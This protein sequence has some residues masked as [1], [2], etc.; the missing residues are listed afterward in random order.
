MQNR[1]VSLKI[2]FSLVTLTLLQNVKADE[3]MWLLFNLSAQKYQKM[4]SLGLDIAKD[5]LFNHTAPSLKDAIVSLNNGSCTGSFISS[6]GLIITNHHC[7]L[8]DVQ[9]HSSV[10]NN[11][12]ENGFWAIN[13]SSELPNPGQTASVLIEALDVTDHILKQIPEKV[14]EQRR[15]FLIDSISNEIITKYETNSHYKAEISHF[16]EGNQFILLLSEVFEDVRLVAS[17]PSSIGQ[18]GKEEDNWMWP[19]HAADFAL[20]RVYTGPDGKPAPYNEKNIPYNPKRVL[21]INIDGINLNDFTMV[22]GFPGSTQRFISSYGIEEIEQVINPVIKDVRGTKQ[23]IWEGSM[24]SNPDIK[25]QYASKFA[26]SSNYWKYAIGQNLAIR[27]KG[28]VV[29]RQEL[30]KKF[31]QWLSDHPEK[32]TEYG[33]IIPALGMVHAFKTSLVKTSVVTMETLVSGPDLFLLAL[34]ALYYKTRLDADGG[35]IAQTDDAKEEFLK[36]ANEILKDFDSE[37]DKK[38]FVAMLDYY[39]KNLSDS[40]RAP[41]T[42]LFELK[43]INNSIDLANHIYSNSILTNKNRFKAFMANPNPEKLKNDPALHFVGTVMTNYGKS[44]F[45]MEEIDAQIESLMR[46]YIKGLMEMY[47]DQ[48]FYPDAN[49]SMRL[50]YGTVQS[51]KPHDGVT[52]KHFT[53]T[54][55]LLQKTASAPLIYQMPADFR[56]LLNSSAFGKY[57]NTDGQMPVCFITNNDITGGNS[58]S[59]VLNGKG[60]LVGLAFDGNWEGMASDLEYMHD[61]QMCVNVD[62]RYIL[63]ILEKYAGMHWLLD[64]ITTVG[65]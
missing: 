3:G 32:L 65:N 58:G 13:K 40:L 45:I 17:P 10:T 1:I 46:K 27:N 6:S 2:V 19:R 26:E 57:Q 51:Y 35:D 43:S 8:S 48:E 49:S 7:I 47:P 55:G 41:V 16:Y 31:T 38:V 39:R 30:E 29:R 25:I 9:W 59:P 4:Q 20:L 5:S 37:L 22:V 64:E 11:Y 21:P 60:E 23:A 33:H 12:I 63:F 52:Y 24:K 50:S 56:N 53:T 14:A 15:S 34:E 42:E 44:Y 61:V 36:S 28:M 62:I 54:N 18:F